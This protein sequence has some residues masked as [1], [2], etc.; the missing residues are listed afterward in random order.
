MSICKGNFHRDLGTS[1]PYLAQMSLIKHSLSQMVIP[2]CVYYYISCF[3]IVLQCSGA[4]HGLHLGS[5]PICWNAYMLCY[6]LSPPFLCRDGLSHQ[7][8]I[9]IFRISCSVFILCWLLS[10]L[11][12]TPFVLAD[13]FIHQLISWGHPHD[14]FLEFRVLSFLTSKV[15]SIFYF[16]FGRWDEKKY[17]DQ[18]VLHGSSLLYFWYSGVFTCQTI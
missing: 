12:F 15:N 7:S 10:L 18:K 5:W 6:M 9:R 1:N 2:L 13:V 14:T 8:A 16:I 4:V 17:G 11:L 3:Y